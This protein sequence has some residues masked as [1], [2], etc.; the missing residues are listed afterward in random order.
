M[1]LWNFPVKPV[2]DPWCHEGVF[3]PEDDEDVEVSAGKFENGKVDLPKTGR[4]L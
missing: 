1:V 3:S 2:E 4:L